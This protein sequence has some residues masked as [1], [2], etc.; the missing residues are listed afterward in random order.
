MGK[1]F[2]YLGFISSVVLEKC[3]NC[4]LQDFKMGRAYKGENGKVIVRGRF[5]LEVNGYSLQNSC[6]ENPMDRGVWWAGHHGVAKS[7]TKLSH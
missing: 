4:V 3:M 7:R 6:L 5:P 2:V 1:K